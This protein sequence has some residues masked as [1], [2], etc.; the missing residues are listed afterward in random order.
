MN[1]FSQ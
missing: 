1:W